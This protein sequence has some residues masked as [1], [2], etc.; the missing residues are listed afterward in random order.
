MT[1][2]ILSKETARMLLKN[3]KPGAMAGAFLMS[4]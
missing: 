1:T 2:D 4:D 3:E